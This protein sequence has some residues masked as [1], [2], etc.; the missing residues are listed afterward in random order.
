M[1]GIAAVRYLRFALLTSN[2]LLIFQGI[3][4]SGPTSAGL[5]FQYSGT[6][7]NTKF[8]GLIGNFHVNRISCKQ[9]TH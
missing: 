2:P 5:C 4:G 1:A 9:N 3:H 7:L 6:P 8:K